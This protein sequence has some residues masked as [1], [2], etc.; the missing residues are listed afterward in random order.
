MLKALGDMKVSLHTKHFAVIYKLL[1]LDVHIYGAD[2]FQLFVL[3]SKKKCLIKKTFIKNYFQIIVC[4]MEKQICIFVLYVLF[5][6]LLNAFYVLQNAVP[7]INSQ[8]LT[9]EFKPIL[10]HSK[11]SNDKFLCWTDFLILQQMF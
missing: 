11:M 8:N 4:C 1:F 6:F 2:I 7:I 9:Y 3:Y 10:H 5:E